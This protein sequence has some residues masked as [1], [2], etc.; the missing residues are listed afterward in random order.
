MDFIS[1]LFPMRLFNSCTRLF[2]KTVQIPLAFKIAIS[3]GI[4]TKNAQHINLSPATVLPS[5]LM[6]NAAVFKSHSNAL[7]FQDILLSSFLD[8]HGLCVSLQ[9]VNMNSYDGVTASYLLSV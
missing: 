7:N 1:A 5:Y 3:S 9:S 2:D 6:K 8:A 4:V